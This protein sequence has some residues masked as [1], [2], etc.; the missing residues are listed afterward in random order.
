M[1]EMVERV[2]H[3]LRQFPLAMPRDAMS[4]RPLERPTAEKMAR[5]A[6]EAMRVPT[7]EMKAAWHEKT[8][9]QVDA[10]Y[11][12]ARAWDYLMGWHTGI[13]AAL[14]EQKDG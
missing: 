5:A 4:A 10:D 8:S 9:K 13:D 11:A 7:K 14:E 1:S 3:A 2:I 12:G 6:I